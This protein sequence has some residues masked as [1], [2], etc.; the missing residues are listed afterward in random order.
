MKKRF[1]PLI[2]LV[3]VAL[4]PLAACKEET[5]FESHEA[6]ISEYFAAAKEG[7]IER[8]EHA[9]DSAIELAPENAEAFLFRGN[10]HVQKQEF[11]RAVTDYSKAIVLGMESA[12]VYQNRGN[13]RSETDDL[14]GALFDLTKAR[15]LE[16]NSSEIAYNLS[17]IHHLRGDTILVLQ[18]LRRCLALEEVDVSTLRPGEKVQVSQ[19]HFLCSQVLDGLQAQ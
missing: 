12:P 5:V 17:R 19:F 2:T 8:A 11:E 16:P 15:E 9:L 18:E 3:T 10:F 4:L 6:A 13:A 14:D 7:D 1:H